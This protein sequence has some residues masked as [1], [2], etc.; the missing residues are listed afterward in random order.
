MMS[1]P[2]PFVALPVAKLINPEPPPEDVPELKRKEPLTPDVPAFIVFKK[3]RPL[4]VGE[5]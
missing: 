5:L 1:P 4:V 3:M 2:S